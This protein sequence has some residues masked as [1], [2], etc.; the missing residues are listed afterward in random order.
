MTDVPTVSPKVLRTGLVVSVSSMPVPGTKAVL[1]LP[2]IGYEVRFSTVDIRNMPPRPQFAAFAKEFRHQFSQPFDLY[3]RRWFADIRKVVHE[4]DMQVRSIGRL[5]EDTPEAVE[6]MLPVVASVNDVLKARCVAYTSALQQLGQTAYEAG[7][8]AAYR[9]AK[10]RPVK[11]AVTVE[12]EWVITTPVPA[13][14]PNVT[15]TRYVVMPTTR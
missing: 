10:M 13:A 1:V 9:A 6:Q 7:L 8:A 2:S 15:V 11:S 14:V 4:N 12:A 5:A 3:R